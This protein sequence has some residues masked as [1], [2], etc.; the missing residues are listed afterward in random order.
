[1]LQQ[2][3]HF[4]LKT[5]EIPYQ[6]I[7]KRLIFSIPTFFYTYFLCHDKNIIKTF[8]VTS[9][10]F[11]GSRFKIFSIFTI[12]SFFPVFFSFSVFIKKD[13]QSFRVRWKKMRNFYA[14]FHNFRIM[15]SQ[16]LPVAF[17]HKAYFFI[18]KDFWV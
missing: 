3:S 18:S 12:F 4:C 17:S 9:K 1:M 15:I 16:C 8:S 6:N 10:V 5:R 14:F 11:A 13:S 7:L 2:H